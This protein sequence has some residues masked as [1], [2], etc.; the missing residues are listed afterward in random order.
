M[1]TDPRIVDDLVTIPA[2]L[3][4]L[5]LK[6][7]R[8]QWGSTEELD[9]A[10]HAAHVAESV[11]LTAKHFEQEGPQQMHGLYIDG[12]ET[13]ICHT[14]T[15]PNSPEI[16]RALTGAWNWLYDNASALKGAEA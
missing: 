16:A 8:A 13:V 9:G 6:I 11:R 3:A 12:T 1:T 14:G 2:D 15:S 10:A 4:A 7:G 5:V